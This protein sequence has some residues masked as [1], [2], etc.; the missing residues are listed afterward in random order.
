MKLLKSAASAIAFIASLWAQA[1]PMAVHGMLIFG[2]KTTY[3]SHLPMFHPP[4]DYQLIMQIHLEGAKSVLNKYESLKANGDTLFTIA[5]EVMDLA[6]VV[7]GSTKQFKAQLFSGHFERGGQSIGP[8]T[9]VVET[10]VVNKKL[11]PLAPQ[12][13]QYT[14][15]G[16][17]GEY[18]AAHLIN[19]KP[20]F[21]YIAKVGQP[22]KMHFSTCGRRICDDSEPPTKIPVPDSHLPVLTN[23]NLINGK[24]PAKGELLAGIDGSALILKVIYVEENELAH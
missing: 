19:G 1:D 6:L 20:S 18:F 16:Q 22:Y 12:Q 5:P 11:D 4:H 13:N 3:A 23:T 24:I 7:N 10:F 15:F 14:I 8:V 2:Q 17:A 21:D 9:V